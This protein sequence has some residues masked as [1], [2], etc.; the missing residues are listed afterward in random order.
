MPFT[1]FK[2]NDKYFKFVD[3]VRRQNDPHKYYY[4][5]QYNNML[6]NLKINNDTLNLIVHEVFLNTISVELYQR[7][8][9]NQYIRIIST[10]LFAYCEAPKKFSY[11]YITNEEAYEIMNGN[12]EAND[13]F[14]K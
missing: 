9:T 7:K 8:D 3:A 6:T 5:D 2:D 1:E 4:Y 12:I 10:A 13:Y 14:S 11:K